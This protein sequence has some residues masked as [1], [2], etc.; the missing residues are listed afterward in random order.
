MLA[1]EFAGTQEGTIHFRHLLPENGGFLRIASTLDEHVAQLASVLQRSGGDARRDA[2]A[3]SRRFIR[4]H[5]VDRPATPV[6]VDA[7]EALAAAPARR[8]NRRPRGGIVVRPLLIAAVV[9][10]V[11]DGWIRDPAAL[12]RLRKQASSWSRRSA[13]RVTKARARWKKYLQKAW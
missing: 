8:R 4:P 6:F 1:P 7:V 12:T 3:S 13:K 10:V 2:A 11:I 5:G 9:P